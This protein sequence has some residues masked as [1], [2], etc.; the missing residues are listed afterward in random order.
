[1]LHV[2]SSLAIIVLPVKKKETKNSESQLLRNFVENKF[3]NF[4]LFIYLWV[5]FKTMC[6]FKTC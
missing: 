6:Y 3:Y 4:N 1:M 5:A 2:T